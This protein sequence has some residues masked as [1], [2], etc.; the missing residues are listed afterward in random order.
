[1][2]IEILASITV[3]RVQFEGGEVID[4]D[5]LTPGQVESMILNGYARAVPMSIALTPVGVPPS[6]ELPP[7]DVIPP[8]VEVTTS[9]P[10]AASAPGTKNTAKK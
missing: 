1:M 3:D 4:A 5:E 8:V 6:E 2:R 9:A 7:V 10:V